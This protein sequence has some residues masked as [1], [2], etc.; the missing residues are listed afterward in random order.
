VLADVKPRDLTK[1]YG[2]RNL[3]EGNIGGNPLI[4]F[5]TFNA[6]TIASRRLR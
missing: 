1:A 4:A 5:E 2:M 6:T 3:D